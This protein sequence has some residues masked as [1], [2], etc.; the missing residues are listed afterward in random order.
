MNQISEEKAMAR[1]QRKARDPKPEQISAKDYDKAKSLY[2]N[3]IK[4]A[5]SKAAEYMQ[6]VSSAFKSVKKLCGIQPSAAKAALKIVEMEDAKAEDWLRSFN[7]IL[8]SHNIDPNPKDLVDAMQGGTATPSPAS[9]KPDLVVVPP[10]DGTE[11]DLTDAA[12][13]E[14]RKLDLGGENF[15]EATPEELAKQAG[16]GGAPSDE[17]D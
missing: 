3:D 15:T 12:D 16:R 7:G 17:Q 5:R 4:P 2:F 8:R 14:A 1:A 6:E 10:S 13:T 11:S 9:R